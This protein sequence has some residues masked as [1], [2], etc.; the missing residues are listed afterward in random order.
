VKVRLPLQASPT[1]D[2]IRLFLTVWLAL[3]LLGILLL[4]S[5]GA[6]RFVFDGVDHSF[7]FR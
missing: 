3:W 7:S 4:A 1:A 5:F 6:V 2:G